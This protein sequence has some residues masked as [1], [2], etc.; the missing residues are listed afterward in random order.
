MIREFDEVKKYLLGKYGEPEN[1]PNG[2][3]AIPTET[4]KGKA[5]MKYEYPKGDE[6]FMLFWDEELKISW[7]DN[8]KPAPS[9]TP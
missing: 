7:Y 3:Y 6:N 9:Q 8:P 5:F 4:S 2:V 1:V